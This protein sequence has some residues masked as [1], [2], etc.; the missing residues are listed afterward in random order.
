MKEMCLG[1]EGCLLDRHLLSTQAI[2]YL[3]ITFTATYQDIFTRAISCYLGSFQVIKL[4]VNAFVLDNWRELIEN[5]V[6]CSY[7]FM[8]K[9]FSATYQAL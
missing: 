4:F 2:V 5:D 7:C 9:L 3:I 8:T 1:S 6:Y